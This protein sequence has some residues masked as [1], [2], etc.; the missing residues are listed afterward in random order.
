VVRAQV[1]LILTAGKLADLVILEKNPLT[2]PAETLY[3][4]KVKST[5]KEGKQIYPSR[6][7]VLTNI[8]SI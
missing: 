1:R 3:T 6:D 2:V 4:I 7:N 5:W 8:R